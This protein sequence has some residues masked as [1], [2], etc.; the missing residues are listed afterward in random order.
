MRTKSRLLRSGAAVTVTVSAMVLSL[1]TTSANAASARPVTSYTNGN[2]IS[3]QTSGAP[4]QAALQR[5]A[6]LDKLA[7]EL[8]GPG[9][10]ESTHTGDYAGAVVDGAAGTLTV[11]W[12][13]PATDLV[14][15][16]VADGAA[17]GVRVIVNAAKYSA[18]QLEAART[19]LEHTAIG[20][21]ASVEPVAAMTSVEVNPDGSGLSVGYDPAETHLSASDFSAHARGLAGVPVAATTRPSGS[22][23]VLNRQNDLAPFVA[24]ARLIT[25]NDEYCSSG[26]DG[27][28]GGH[29]VLLTAAH[30]GTSGTFFNGNYGTYGTA[31]GHNNTYD[32]TF[33]KVS[34]NKNQYYEGCWCDTTGFHKNITSVGLSHDGDY[35]CTSGAM[36]GVHCNLLVTNAGVDLDGYSNVVIAKR[37]STDTSG[38]NW[39]AAAAGDSGG[40]VVASA[41]GTY[42]VNMQARGLIHAGLSSSWLACSPGDD[43]WIASACYGTVLYIGMSAITNLGF[44]TKTS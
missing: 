20:K 34:S 43:T 44:T 29:P 21:T 18:Q 26:F 1:A 35:V 42:G 23:V 14:N 15:S 11:Y 41:D 31:I 22:S 5:Q 10:T 27:T 19:K 2:V 4:D 17:D 39:F 38:N 3:S 6:I 40:P 7:D 9:A 37:T 12:H 24:G 28:Y 36:S 13:G 8:A 33:I 25:P 32:V 30:C 16:V